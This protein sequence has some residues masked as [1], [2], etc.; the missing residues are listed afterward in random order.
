MTIRLTLQ[1]TVTL[2]LFAGGVPAGP[3]IPAPV[4][5]IARR[6]AS[7]VV[8]DSVVA[9][10][11]YVSDMAVS[12]DNRVFVSDARLATVFELE[13]SGSLRRT[14]GRSG[15]GP[16]EFYAVAMLGFRGDSLW[17]LDAG[18]NR[19]SLFP[20]DGAGR[21]LVIRLRGVVPRA[22]SGPADYAFSGMPESMLSDGTMLTTQQEG[23]RSK[24]VASQIHV[25]RTGRDL[26]ILDTLG[27]ISQQHAVIFTEWTDGASFIMQPFNDMPIFTAAPDGS[28][29][30]EVERMASASSAETSFRLV[31]RN[32]SAMPLFTRDITYRPRRL[33]NADIERALAIF[34]DPGVKLP[35]PV[36]VDSIRSKLYRPGF[37][38]PVREVHVGRD[39]TTWLRVNFADSPATGVDWLVLSPRGFPL[40]RVTTPADFRL[41]EADRHTLWGVEGDPLDIPVLAKYVVEG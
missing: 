28:L 35:G 6:D 17:A 1:A 14:I 34:S 23:D 13:A 40:A 18:L 31:G 33:R 15:G 22:G 9:Q 4:R 39:G 20:L 41:M 12:P 24:P 29:V 25:F 10:L 37:F 8:P 30:V 11:S 5:Q 27:V 38:P 7:F 32:G 3:S 2:S 21:P 16:G 19:V 26:A 36:T